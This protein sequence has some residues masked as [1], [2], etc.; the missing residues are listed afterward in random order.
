MHLRVTLNDA[1]TAKNAN[2]ELYISIKATKLLE[3]AIQY[4]T[5]YVKR[6]ISIEFYVDFCA[7]GKCI[8]S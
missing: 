2:V 3:E 4:I 6:R 7:R 5:E 1:V 8:F